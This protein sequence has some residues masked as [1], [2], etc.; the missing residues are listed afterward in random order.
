MCFAKDAG[1]KSTETNRWYGTPY[2]DGW[3]A[4]KADE[5]KRLD[6]RKDTDSDPSLCSSFVGSTRFQIGA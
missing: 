5:D 4:V 3:T 1:S 6:Q 2:S